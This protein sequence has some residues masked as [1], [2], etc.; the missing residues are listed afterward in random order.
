MRSPHDII[1]R[2]V[3]TEQSTYESGYGK[4][5]F[6]VR[7]DAGK[8]EIRSAVEKLFNVKV[9][10]VNTLKYKGKKKRLGVHQGRTASYKK[11]VV[12]IDQDPVAEKYLLAGGKVG[13]ST[14]KYKTEIEEFGFG[15]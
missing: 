8:P 6:I 5:T 9:L 13:T 1:I 11:A 2:P 12:T 15:Q 10:K 7:S 3:I 4:Y 14:K